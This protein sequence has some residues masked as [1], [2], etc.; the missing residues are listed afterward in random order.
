MPLPR[1]TTQDRRGEPPFMPRRALAVAVTLVSLFTLAGQPSAFPGGTP[2]VVT[3]MNTQCAGCHS[4]ADA[5]QLR[6]Q[7]PDAAANMLRENRHYRALGA[8]ERNY[9]KLTPEDR[10]RL[11]AAV[12]AV[13]ENSRVEIAASALKVRPS[14]TFTVTVTTQGGAGP[15]VGVMLTDCDLRASSSPVQV[16]GFYI[17]EEPVVT[18][19]DGK[20]QTAFLDGRAKELGRNINYVNIQ[21]V[22]A[23]PEANQWSRCKVT[24]TLT[25]PA[26]PGRYTISAAYLFGT[27]KAIPLGRV[28]EAGGRIVPAGGGGAGSGRILFAK[29]L[30]IVV[31]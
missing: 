17:S 4:S 25:A 15:V 26:R 14:G 8:G 22:Q 21:G 29:P 7:S 18:G 16:S 3:N 2:R 11:L 31:G 19:P 12:K 28:E 27:E 1:V 13:D 10:Q 24:W 9:A 23:D 6:D 5:G 30:N 20:P